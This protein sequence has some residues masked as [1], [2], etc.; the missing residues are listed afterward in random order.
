MKNILLFLFFII[1]C[2]L[3]SYS[4]YF[5]LSNDSIYYDTDENINV[6]ERY[7]FYYIQKYLQNTDI[8]R[9]VYFQQ[10]MHKPPTVYLKYGYKREDVIKINNYIDDFLGLLIK[11]DIESKTNISLENVFSSKEPGFYCLN[12]IKLDSLLQISKNKI[13]GKKYFS[14][15]I[16]FVDRSSYK[17]Y[18]Y[19]PSFL[20]PYFENS[21][22]NRIIFIEKYYKEM[23]IKILNLIKIDLDTILEVKTF[24]ID[25]NKDQTVLQNIDLWSKKLKELKIKYQ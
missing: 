4:Q 16:S 7:T 9:I 20:F 24:N 11:L 10:L 17:N 12:F 18:E 3:K 19:Y 1:F 14:R 25:N 13:V 23:D 8:M 2:N 5:E 21:V 6:E 15:N 22:E